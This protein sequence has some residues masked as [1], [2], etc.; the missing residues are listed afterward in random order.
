MMAQ[1]HPDKILN[2]DC[3]EVVQRKARDYTVDDLLGKIMTVSDTQRAISRNANRRLALEVMVMRLA[4][5]WGEKTVA[6]T[7]EPVQK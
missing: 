3:L 6:A 4:S 5:G 1:F 7:K 2:Q